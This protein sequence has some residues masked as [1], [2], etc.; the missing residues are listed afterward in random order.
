[1]FDK[2]KRILPCWGLQIVPENTQRGES[3]NYLGYNIGLQKV[4]IRRDQL[5]TLHLFSK[6]AGRYKLAMAHNWI[7]N[8]SNLFQNLHGH[9]DLNSPRKLSAEAERELALVEKKL[10][11]AH[12]SKTSLDK[13]YTF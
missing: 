7:N 5:W 4:Q 6:F 8:S 9:K 10:Q 2:I 1:M 11:D 3:I 12:M 13:I